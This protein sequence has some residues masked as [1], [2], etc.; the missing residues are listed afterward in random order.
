METYEEFQA[1]IAEL[2]AQ[3]DEIFKKEQHEALGKI[4]KLMGMYKISIEDIQ[5]TVKKSRKVSEVKAK[6]RDP[7]TGSEWSGRGRAPRWLEGKNRDDFR[8]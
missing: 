5:G 6:Y 4:K 1:K 2:Q 8:V 3:A 7:I